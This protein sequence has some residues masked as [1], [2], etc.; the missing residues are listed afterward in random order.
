MVLESYEQKQQ[1]EALYK[2]AEKLLLQ[3]IGLLDWQPKKRTYHLDKVPF[4]VEDTITEAYA[5]DTF[6]LIE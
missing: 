6:C 1:A 3:E 5:N 4:Q 2:E